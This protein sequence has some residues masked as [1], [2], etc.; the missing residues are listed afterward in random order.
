MEEDMQPRT[1]PNWSRWLSSLLLALF[2]AGAVAQEENATVRPAQ[3]T[4]RIVPLSPEQAITFVDINA[5]GQ[6]A[7]TEYVG[8]VSRAKFFDGRSVRDIGTLGGPGAIA[9]AVNDL[10]QVV[11]TASVNAAGTLS[12]AYRWSRQTGMIDLG[13]RLPGESSGTD[14]NNFGQVTGGAVFSPGQARRG[15]LW[16]PET[17]TV[18]NIGTIDLSS[19]GSALNDAGTITGLTGG[20]TIRAFRWTRREGMRIITPIGN[21]FTTANDINAAGHIVGAA[22]LTANPSQPAHAFLWT[23]REGL[24]DLGAGFANR[25]IAEKINDRDMVIGN[26]RDFVDFPHGFVWTRETGTTEIGAGQPRTVTYTADLN[27]YGQVVGGFGDHAYVWTRAQGVVDLNTV[28]RAAPE[29]LVLQGARAISD[30]GAIVAQANTGLVLLVPTSA[31]GSEAPVVGPVRVTGAPRVQALLSFSA[32]FRD[33]DPGD[34]HRATW[35]WGDGARTTAI[36][37]ERSGRANVSGQ[38]AYRSP[39]TYTVRLTVTDSGG[40]S[41]TVHRNVVVRGPVPLVQR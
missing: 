28:L 33:A 18:V 31:S 37:S 29:G 15:F 8:G 21:E 9:S 36:V 11:G 10:G 4:Y 3:T 35:A 39:G 26:V 20:D 17:R 30:N 40:R 34:S 22:V 6:V 1:D 12:H 38:H 16:T 2:A 19:Y 7:F 5:T 14:I 41:T 13:R 25:T 23:P 24:I 27:K 32:A